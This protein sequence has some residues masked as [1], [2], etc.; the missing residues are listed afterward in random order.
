MKKVIIGTDEDIVSVNCPNCDNWEALGID[1]PRK[2]LNSLPIIK[3]FP[4][5]E[6]TNE[7]SIHKCTDCNNEFQVEWD[8]RTCMTQ[9]KCI[10][11]QKE[12]SLLCCIIRENEI[13]NSTLFESFDKIFEI[14]DAFIEKYGVDQ[15]QWGIDFGMEYEETVVE[16]ATLYVK[17]KIMRFSTTI[18][19]LDSGDTEDVI[20]K[21]GD[22]DEAKDEDVFFYIKSEHDLESFKK[23]GVHD[24]II[25]KTVKIT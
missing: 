18:K 11:K 3:W 16:F 8:Y 23:E 9:Q 19:W 25:L 4:D 14:A 6:D 22:I 5:S 24:W 12:M 21:I 15:V 10:A 20:L 7:K 13:I 2:R 1:D 17:N